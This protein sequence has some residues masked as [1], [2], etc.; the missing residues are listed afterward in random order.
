MK[1]GILTFTGTQSHGACLQ[2]YALRTKVAELCGEAAVIPY[3]CAAIEAE[4]EA[5]RP[6]NARG[7]KKKIG[8]TL[9]YPVILRRWRKFR[10]FEERCL[11][12]PAK[13]VPSAAA[14][15]GYGRIIV[16]SD[17]LSIVAM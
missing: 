7:L 3:R 9:R 1:I 11:G 4:N 16:G 2:A 17:Q 15:E 5:K 14:F 6:K 8:A 10:S 12:L 13:P